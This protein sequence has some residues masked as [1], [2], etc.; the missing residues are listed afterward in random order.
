MYEKVCNYQQKLSFCS[1][2]VFS[3]LFLIW[4]KFWLHRVLLKYF[5]LVV[6]FRRRTL[7]NLVMMEGWCCL[8]LWTVIFMCLTPFVEH[9]Y[10]IS[11]P[12][13]VFVSSF[14]HTYIRL[15]YDASD[16][17]SVMQQLSTYSVKPVAEELTLDA[18][19]SPQGSF[20]VSGNLWVFRVIHRYAM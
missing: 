10:V 16:S 8:Q 5:R 15:V 12:C 11:F 13:S 2:D 4:T 14:K 18:T 7:W 3:C 17:F 6:I 1:F 9:S 20:V 19:F